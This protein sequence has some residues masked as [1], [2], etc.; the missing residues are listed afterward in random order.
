MCY[1]TCP[2]KQ[3]KKLRTRPEGAVNLLLIKVNFH[4]G[5]DML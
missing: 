4:Q 2:G 5:N 3:I 1:L